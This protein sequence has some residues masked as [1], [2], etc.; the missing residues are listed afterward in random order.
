[1]WLIYTVRLHWTKHFVVV[2]CQQ[3]STAA[4]DLAGNP[5][6]LPPISSETLS[7]LNLCM[8]WVC[9]HNHSE[10]FLLCLEAVVLLGATDHL[11]LSKSF[12]FCFCL[13]PRAF[14][15]GDI[16]LGLSVPKFLTVDIV[17]LWF[18]VLIPIYYK[19]KLLSCRFSEALIFWP[20]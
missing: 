12:C 7:G 17:H 14:R 11:C 2:V 18:S 10:S 19:K 13:A 3:V 5:C 4:F 20:V 6:P 9:W 15:R 1:M 16:Q 8:S